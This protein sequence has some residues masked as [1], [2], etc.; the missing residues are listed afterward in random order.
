MR[1]LRYLQIC[2]MASL[3]LSLSLSFSDVERAGVFFRIR[4]WD[5]LSWL[6]FKTLKKDCGRNSKVWHLD[7]LHVAQMAL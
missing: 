4:C 2:L 7:L 3:S 1:S 6:T 5:A